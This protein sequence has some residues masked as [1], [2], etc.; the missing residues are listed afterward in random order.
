MSDFDLKNIFETAQRIQSE[1]ARVKDDLANRT[2][3]GEAGG[4]LVACTASGK[5]DL[6]SLSLDASL[7]SS[8]PGAD[9]KKLLEDLIVGAVNVALDRARQLAQEELAKAAGGLPLPPGVLGG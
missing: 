4:G 8:G 9:T 1:V 7:L 5:G 6:L 3:T 2:V